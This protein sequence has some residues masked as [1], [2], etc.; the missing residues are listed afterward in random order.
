MGFD[1]GAAFLD[2]ASIWGLDDTNGGTAGLDPVDDSFFLNSAV[3]FGILWDTQIG[4]LRFN[5]TR[6]INK[7]DYDREQTFD[8]TISTRF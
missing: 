3:G 8:L 6:A 4:P 7:R 5:F 1:P 2:A